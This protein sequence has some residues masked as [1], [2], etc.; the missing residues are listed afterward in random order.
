M[1]TQAHSSLKT[2]KKKL[3]RKVL[4]SIKKMAETEVKCE[5]A[6]EVRGGGVGCS[7]RRP[8]Q[9]K[10]CKMV[11]LWQDKPAAGS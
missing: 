6:E 4:D 2:I 8:P 10:P 7:E 5:K 1:Y 9:A 3:V 11:S